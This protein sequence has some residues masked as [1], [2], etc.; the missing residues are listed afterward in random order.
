MFGTNPLLG[1]DR[2]SGARSHR[3][4]PPSIRRRADGISVERMVKRVFGGREID[5]AISTSDLAATLPVAAEGRV[6][7]KPPIGSRIPLSVVAVSQ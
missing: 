6:G 1:D 7:K 2:C 4:T 3:L 5:A